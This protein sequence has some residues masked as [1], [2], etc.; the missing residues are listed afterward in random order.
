MAQRPSHQ[1]SLC[2]R[3]AP[4]GG[5][6]CCLFRRRAPAASDGGEACTT[7]PWGVVADPPLKG[8]PHGPQ[9]LTVLTWLQPGPGK[10]QRLTVAHAAA[11]RGLE[12]Q[13][14]VWD[15]PQ[16]GAWVGQWARSRG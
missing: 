1:T 11:R 8:H 14:P 12:A 4:R 6:T 7:V 5:R 2:P 9:T 3:A 10:S 15:G 13:S 16:L